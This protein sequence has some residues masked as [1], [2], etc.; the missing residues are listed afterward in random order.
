[1]AFNRHKRP[2]SIEALLALVRQRPRPVAKIA[3]AIVAGIALT[4]LSVWTWSQWSQLCCEAPDVVD[5]APPAPQPVPAPAPEGEGK[6]DCSKVH[7]DEAIIDCLLKV[8]Q[9]GQKD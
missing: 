7:G 2:Q 9:R 5:P 6:V 8:Q 3:L 1:L 4:G